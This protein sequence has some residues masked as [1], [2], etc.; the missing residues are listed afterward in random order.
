MR[1]RHNSLRKLLL[2]SS[3]IAI[4]GGALMGGAASA[5]ERRVFSFSQKDL[6][7]ALREFGFASGY[8]LVFSSEMVEGK[9]A[10]AVNGTYSDEEALNRLLAGT[11]LSFERKPSGV[12]LLREEADKLIKASLE[13]DAQPLQIAQA[14]TPARVSENAASPSQIE[15]VVVTGTR[16]VREGYEAPTPL[17]VV[18][19][20]ALERNAS[21]N[22]TTLLATM[23][24]LAGTFTSASSTAFL[25]QGLAGI[26]SLNLRSLG[27]NRVL[28]LLDGQRTVGSTYAGAVDVGNFPSQLMQRVDVV[29]GGASAVYGSD[30]VTGVVNFVLDR[31]FTGVKGELSGGLTNYGDDRNYEVELSA[32]FGFAGGRGHVLVSGQH[33]YNS[34]IQGDGGR[35]WNREGWATYAN[36]NYSPTNGQP[37]ILL[38]PNTSFAT[39]TAGG[40]VVAGPLKGTA[41][42]ADGSPYQFTYG[43]LVGASLMTGG[44]ASSNYITQYHDFDPRQ[45]N[46]N[47]FTRI[48][49]DLTDEINAFVQYSFSQNSNSANNFAAYL[50]GTPTAYLIQIDNPYLAPSVRAAM[51]A[52]NVT[53]IPIGSWNDDMPRTGGFNTRITNRFN[54]GLDGVLPAFGT[55][56]NWN[57]Y[58]SYGATK[59][60]LHN[61]AVLRSRYSLAIDAVVNPANG[62]IVCRSTLTDSTNGC[63]PW[64]ALGVGVNANNAASFNYMTGD[65]GFLHGVNSQQTVAASISGEP[66]SNWAGPVSLAMS[67]EH[68]VEEIDAKADQYSSAGLRAVG[69][70]SSLAG[71][72]SVTEGALESIVPLV[73]GTSWAENWELSL[74]VRFTDYELAGYVTTWKVG[75][76]YSPI[77]DIKFR[78][79]R[80]RDIRAPNIQEQFAAPSYQAIGSQ[81]ID[82]FLNNANTPGGTLYV[83]GGNIGLVP[84]KADTT[85]VGVVLSP[86]FIEGFTASVDYWDIN[87]KGAIQSIAPQ[88]VIDT[89]FTGQRP[90]LCASIIR[91]PASGTISNVLV[92]PINLAVQN[93]RG[94]DVEASY[95]LPVST[96]ISDWD[97]D[98]SLHGLMTF[99]LRDYLLT[100]LATGIDVAGQNGPGLATNLNGSYPPNWQ[101]TATGTYQLDNLSTSLTAR[102]FSSGVV[103]NRYIECTSGCPTSTVNNPT[104]N[105]NHIPGAFYLDAN[106][107]YKF[108]V[109]EATTADV[110]FSVANIFNKGVPPVPSSGTTYASLVPFD[111]YGT[112]YRAGIRFRM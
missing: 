107:S 9:T 72:Q 18:G 20:E 61:N 58:F 13:T 16:I 46:D 95:R 80:S 103:D 3:A 90:D 88:Q 47:L 29:T 22:L 62:Q 23:P 75:T 65:G 31:E 89:C 74:A 111:V 67:V 51:A 5:Q 33:T 78:L 68:R 48:S 32:G 14:E 42:G 79:T 85:G 57:A 112:V 30:A 28:V 63:K 37:Q 25:S 83:T 40:I 39:A 2:L 54:A 94:I 6:S 99:Y 69:N 26:Q 24:A 44:D 34:G 38:V 93:V 4:V 71:K 45:S 101:L 1:I 52:R 35:K 104:T 43:S 64:N 87:L 73:N 66:L 7:T 36:P 53:S 96:L 86:R 15:E 109:S 12:I 91:D 11:G 105:R 27:S 97:G 102:A 8:D 41:F 98:L 17:T 10:N 70:F 110:F 82:R 92:S 108:D 50:L 84:E 106:V 55:D 60:S 81:L 19:A 49:Y 76:T 56:W 77:D 100:P 21:S 59:I